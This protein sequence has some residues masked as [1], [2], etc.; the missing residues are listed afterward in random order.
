M[1][2]GSGFVGKALIPTLQKA[3]H[4]VTVLNRGNR[5]IA[6]VSKLVADRDQYEDMIKHSGAFDVVV[7]TSGYT[8]QQAEIAFCAFGEAAGK[9]I[10]LSSAAVYRETPDN[11]PNEG[12]ALGGAKIWGEYGVDKY[13]ADE[14][15]LRSAKCPLAI[16]RPPYLYGPNNANDRESF[17]WSRVLTGRPVIFPGDGTAQLQ[18]L[19][20]QDLA[21]IISHFAEKDFGKRAVYNVAEPETMNAEAWATRVAA[22]SASELKLVSGKAHAAN[23]T[24]RK[25]FP[26]R[27]YS[28]ALDVS[29]FEDEVNWAFRFNFDSG[30]ESTFSSYELEDLKQSSPS[31]AEELLILADAGEA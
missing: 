25:Y 29:K 9:W 24:A 3:G 13:E 28:C 21:G 2:G 15:L 1:I 26:F 6:D 16:L 19:H 12:D 8:K 20:V 4:Q 11:F 31:S 17:V 27:D 23:V 7:D 18:F 10:H 22:V 5:E 30:I 14:F